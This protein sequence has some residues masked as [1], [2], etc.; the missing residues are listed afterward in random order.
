MN[1][2]LLKSNTDKV[3][4]GVC[5]GLA[6]Y[7]NIDVTI[8]RLLWLGAIF[9]GGVGFWLYLIAAIIIPRE[10]FDGNVVYE[11][12]TQEYDSRYSGLIMGFFLV[13]VGVLL[14]LNRFYNFNFVRVL[15]RLGWPSLLIVIGLIVMVSS[16]RKKQ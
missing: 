8:I 15:F 3:F 11:Q 5:G 13:I 14:I 9:I 12:R 16:F 6:N 4:A 10:P 7:F 2:R 1:K